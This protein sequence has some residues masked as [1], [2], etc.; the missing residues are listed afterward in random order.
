MSQ[1]VT[2]F[3]HL[4][5][6]DLVDLYARG[7]GQL[8]SCLFWPLSCPCSHCFFIDYLWSQLEELKK[9]FRYS[10]NQ[11]FTT[12]LWVGRLII[13]DSAAMG[14]TVS[15][16]NVTMHNIFDTDLLMKN[17]D[18]LKRIYS[19]NISGADRRRCRHTWQVRKNNV[20]NK[21]DQQRKDTYYKIFKNLS[22]M[23]VEAVAG[24]LARLQCPAVT[25]SHRGVF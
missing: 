23:S 19:G 14:P 7:K 12:S 2:E 22:Q 17:F 20:R 8:V 21:T 25:L 9:H 10:F 3:F 5:G 11:Y 18:S 16:S 4:D 6:R 15:F 1:L 13:Q 24:H